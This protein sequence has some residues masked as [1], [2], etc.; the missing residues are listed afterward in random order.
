MTGKV[1]APRKLKLG[2]PEASNS[3][4]VRDVAMK[5]KD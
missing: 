1:L 2:S 5:S 4:G 3:A